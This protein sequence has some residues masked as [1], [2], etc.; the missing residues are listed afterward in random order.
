MFP[1][2]R[3]RRRKSSVVSYWKHSFYNGL[4]FAQFYL[5]VGAGGPFSAQVVKGQNK[6]T[7]SGKVTGAE[8]WSAETPYLYELE[9]HL[10]ADGKVIHKTKERFGFRTFK[11]RP[12]VG[13][14]LNGHKIRL[15]GVNR[16]SFW[17]NSGRCLSRKISYDDVRL[18]KEMNMNAVRMS[19]YPPDVHFLEACDELGLYVLDEL[20]GGQRAVSS[21]EKQNKRGTA[22]SLEQ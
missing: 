13:L 7:L 19:H 2:C 8:P 12:G 16:H 10:F 18:I 4:I 21:M 1:F 22:G 6:V 11:V 17:P 15:K 14:F 20:G 5:G 3:L 9:L